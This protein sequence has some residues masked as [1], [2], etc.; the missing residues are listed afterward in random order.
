MGHSRE[1]R[2][3][4]N[5]GDNTN[6]SRDTDTSNR[7]CYAPRGIGDRL[8]RS[9]RAPRLRSTD[10]GTRMHMVPGQ[11]T[12]RDREQV[13]GTCTGTAEELGM[14][15]DSVMALAPSAA[16]PCKVLVPAGVAAPRPVR[17]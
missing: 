5:S 17:R 10:T 9:Y 15:T 8:R 3:I 11:D 13:L 7:S 16:V 12:C 6:R 14:C 4:G 2:W 1:G